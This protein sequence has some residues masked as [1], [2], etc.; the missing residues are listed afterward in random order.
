MNDQ[1]H[2]P[3]MEP[4]RRSGGGDHDVVDLLRQLTQQGAHLAQEQ[5]SLVQAEVREA[6]HDLKAAIAALASAAVVGIAGLG[7]L[8]MGIAYAVADAIGNVWL[9][10]VIVGVATLIIAFI[11]YT[12]GKKKASA[13]NPKPERSLRTAEDTPAAATGHINTSGGYDG[14]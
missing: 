2:N 5:V 7:V 14:R 11:M 4:G 6:T 8:L 3:A 13:V 10:T 12:A 1:H 9:G